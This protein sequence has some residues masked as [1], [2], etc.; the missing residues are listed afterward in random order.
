MSD[1]NS[2]RNELQEMSESGRT[3]L[4]SGFLEQL[5]ILE[6]E[7]C[8]NQPPFSTRTRGT[9]KVSR[10][11]KRYTKAIM[12]EL[13]IFLCTDD[14]RYADLRKRGENFSGT[15]AAAVAGYVASALGLAVGVVTAGVA[16][17][18]LVLLRVGTGSFCRLMD[19]PRS[20][21]MPSDGAKP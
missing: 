17:A 5:R 13:F 10:L 15:A 2:K 20:T 4:P 9:K 1:I 14:R 6:S 11:A 21:A 16:F 7:I 3:L 19:D 12:A 18:M 8:T